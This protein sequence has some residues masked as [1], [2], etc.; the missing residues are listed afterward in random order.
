MQEKDIF[1]ESIYSVEEC[2]H[3]ENRAQ[4]NNVSLMLSIPGKP[5]KFAKV[6]DAKNLLLQDGVTV[7]SNGKDDKKGY[8]DGIYDPCIILDFGKVITARI[9]LE[10]FCKKAGCRVDIGYAERLVDGYFANHISCP[11]TERFVMREGRKKYSPYA[12]EAFRYVKLRFYDCF[13][14][15]S[16]FSVK[17][18]EENYP[19]NERGT[20]ESGDIQMNSVFDI[21]RYTLRLCCHESVMDTPWREK[22][23]WLGDVSA[24]TLGGVYACFGDTR[25]P[26]KFLSQSA[27]NQFNSGLI[28]MITNRSYDV[29][30]SFSVLPDYSLWWIWAL[31]NHYMYT[32]QENWIHIYYPHV[33][34]ILQT[35][36]KHTDAEGFL[37]NLPGWTFIDWVKL[38]KREQSSVMNAIFYHVLECIGKMAEFK[39]D[40]YYE[41]TVSDIRTSIKNGFMDRYYNHGLG[42]FTDA[43]HEDKLSESI[44]EHSNCMAILAGLCDENTARGIIA[45]LYEDKSV[46][47]TEAQPFFTSIVLKALAKSGRIDLALDTIRERWG[48]RM[49]DCGATSTWEEWSKN[50]SERSGEYVGFMRSLSHA[51]SA[52]PAEFLIRGLMGLFVE[53]PGCGKVSLEPYAADF[54]YKAVFPVPQGEIKVECKGGQIRYSLPDEVECVDFSGSRRDL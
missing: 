6:A 54:D 36:I 14:E 50:G 47:Y 18:V 17:A 31:W 37:V 49:V 45:R 48:K 13:D 22:G 25:L 32:G 39:N 5:L 8:I 10:V 53:Q 33:I 15:L 26:A 30:K 20:F 27:E 29:E 34:K 28:T 24:V 21:S 16:V 9:E 1:A 35:F 3:L 43:R 2:L 46:S 4:P 38:D 41:K 40:E 42:C 12:W 52:F 44:S 51:W 23:Q 7:I 11:F 19:F